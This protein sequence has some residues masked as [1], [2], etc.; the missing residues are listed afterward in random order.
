MSLYSDLTDEQLETEISSLKA[1][2]RNASSGTQ[3]G[4]KSIAGEGRRMEFFGGGGGADLRGL[5]D[6]L[7]SAELE[8]TRRGY[9]TA[10]RA[11]GVS[12]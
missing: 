9:G 5:K 2:I 3:A 8:W 10:G 7:A 4:V 1:K 12:F 6:L 11:I